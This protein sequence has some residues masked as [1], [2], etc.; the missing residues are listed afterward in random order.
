MRALWN[1][2]AP[3]RE[4]GMTTQPEN[5]FVLSENGLVLPDKE[6]IRSNNEGAFLKSALVLPGGEFLLT[7]NGKPSAFAAQKNTELGFYGDDDE[8]RKPDGLYKISFDASAFKKG[9][10]IIAK[11]SGVHLGPDTSDECTINLCGVKEDTTYGLGTVDLMWEPKSHQLFSTD[12]IDGGFKL[13][14]NGTLSDYPYFPKDYRFF[15]LVAWLK[16]AG[17]EEYDVVS[18]CTC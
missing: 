17:K 15:F 7:I 2:T 12:I 18:Y 10:V 14:F 3:W 8:F 9:D 5:K 11:I 1:T 13:T 4:T 16:G 6:Q